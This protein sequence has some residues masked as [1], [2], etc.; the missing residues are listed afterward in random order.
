MEGRFPMSHARESRALTPRTSLEQLRKDAKRW[1]KAVRAGDPAARARLKAAWPKAPAEPVLRD[2]QH[3]L[4]REYGQDSWIALKAELDDLALANKGLAAQAE[5][6]LHGWDGDPARARRLLRRRPDLTRHSLF[7]AAACGDLEE[8][9]R[10]LA[11]D[12]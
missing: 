3:A 10:R 2:L 8:V 7:T 12:P 9:E 4:A 5:V 11:R 6:L 1:L